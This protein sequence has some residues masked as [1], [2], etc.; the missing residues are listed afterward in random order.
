MNYS[1][2]FEENAS[3]KTVYF[4]SSI[5]INNPGKKQSVYVDYV[6]K[7]F[8]KSDI[9]FSIKIPKSAKVTKWD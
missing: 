9:K 1:N 8:N 7:T 3:G 4:P 6:N 5:K 2:Y